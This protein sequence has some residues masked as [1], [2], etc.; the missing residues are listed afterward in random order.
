MATTLSQSDVTN[1]YQEQVYFEQSPGSG[2][3]NLK[4]I[5][6]GDNGRQISLPVGL[7]PAAFGAGVVSLA[8]GAGA[9]ASN[10]AV[11]KVDPAALTA[12][13]TVD[14]SRFLVDNTAAITVP[15]GTTAL[16]SGLRVEEP[17]ITATGTVTAAASLVVTGAPTEG[18]ANYAVLVQAGAS[19][20]TPTKTVASAAAADATGLRVA[21]ATVTL[22]GTTQVTTVQGFV[23]VGTPTLTDASAVT[24]DGYATVYIA[25]APTA[26]GSV[27]LTVGY[28]L[29]VDAG[30]TRLDGDLAV[31]GAAV[32]GARNTVGYASA[33]TVVTSVGVGVH[34][35][36]GTYTDA[37]ATGTIAV[38]NVARIGAATV[39]ATNTITYTDAATL[40]LADPVASTGATF[41]RKYGLRSLGQIFTST[42]V[43]VGGN[44]ATFASTQPTGS[45]VFAGGATAPAGAITTGGAIFSSTTVM[46]KII[47][48]GTA[49]N[50]ET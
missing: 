5:G 39:V 32:S 12:I 7:S 4:T 19:S 16:V 35:P 45:V 48:D 29:W 20:L 28:A 26:G 49:S 17:N 13:A 23:H 18:A 47:A 33:G 41:T 3:T 9:S 46:R 15:T 43:Q 30:T 42:N 2:E 37:G 8:L 31:G 25:A 21:T 24:V 11:V 40:E 6:N 50:I 10:D 1:A 44:T 34:V 27:T 22:T 36:A 38:L 14:I